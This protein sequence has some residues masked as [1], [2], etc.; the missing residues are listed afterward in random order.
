MVDKYDR[1]FPGNGSD[2]SGKIGPQAYSSIEKV[3]KWLN[4]NTFHFDQFSDIDKL[5]DLKRAK[6]LKISVVIPTLNEALTIGNEVTYIKKRFLDAKPLIDEIIVVDSGSEDDTVD[7]AKKSGAKVYLASDI[8]PNYKSYKG[9]GE[10]LW[11]SLY[12]TEGD[13]ILWLDADIKDLS[14]RFVYGILGPILEFDHILYSKAFYF[15]PF[16]ASGSIIPAGGGRVTEILIRPL[17]NMFFKELSGFFQPLSGEYGGKRELLEKLPFSIGYGVETGL[18]IDILMN[19]GLDCI[20]QVD[21]NKRVHRNR[22]IH[23]LSVMAFE[24]LKTFLHRAEKYN[25]IKINYENIVDENHFL[26]I[27]ANKL[28]YELNNEEVV[29]IS[30]QP[31]IEIPEYREKYKK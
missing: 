30:R 2:E 14:G 20:A 27:V 21:L 8:L 9:K 24:I 22:P 7:I 19:F 3:Y 23:E 29:S 31:M 16:H 17:F 28:N 6:N 26:S 13:I 5:I 10:N 12:V 11:K 4:K 25:R 1:G 18:L 15:R